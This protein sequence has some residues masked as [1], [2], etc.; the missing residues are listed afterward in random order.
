MNAIVHP[1]RVAVLDD[2]PLIGKALQYSLEDEDDLVLVGSFKNRKEIVPLLESGEVS[3]LILDYLLG[4]DDIDGIR[5]VRHFRL[6]YPKLKILISSAIE[7]PAVVQQVIKAGVMGFIGKS[8][9]QEELLTA[10]R[11]VAAGKRY[12][13]PDMQFELKKFNEPEKEMQLMLDPQQHSLEEDIE[14][15]VRELTPRELEVIRCYLVGMS[16]SQI[17]AKFNRSRKTISGQKQNALRKL[18]LKSDVE[19]FRFKDLVN[20]IA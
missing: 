8:K 2:H 10:I 6:H 20:G 9:E 7:S 15:L 1:F 11:H 3:L 13:S 14:I 17:A 19:L 18:N 5:L 12:L 16:I 4:N